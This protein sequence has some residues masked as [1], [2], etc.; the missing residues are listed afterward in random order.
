MEKDIL[1]TVISGDNLEFIKNAILEIQNFEKADLLIID[2]G[3]EYDILEEI[4][5]FRSVKCIVRDE[6]SG[7]G[8]CISSAINFARDM[9]YRYLILVDPEGPGYIKDLPVI[10]DN[11]DYGYD[12]VTCSRILEN[13]GYSEID[14]DVIEFFDQLTS[15]LNQVT[16][17]NL[18]DPL[19]INKGIN[20]TTTADLDLTSD[21]HGIMLQLFVQGSYFG[22]NIIEIPSEA[23]SRFGE[24]LNLYDNPFETFAAVIETEK[25]LYNKGSIN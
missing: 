10:I 22:Y 20:I 2:D 13:S 9:G 24:E 7:I 11:L 19:S 3:S 16:E 6:S 8:A 14:Q 21:D 23:E 17:L 25:Y 1:I 12:I 15:Y 18:S 5:E 4:K